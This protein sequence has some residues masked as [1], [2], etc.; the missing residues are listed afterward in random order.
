MRNYAF[1]IL[2]ALRCASNVDGLKCYD[3]CVGP[4]DSVD[5][6]WSPLFRAP[7]P[8][9]SVCLRLERL[10][11]LARGGIYLQTNFHSTLY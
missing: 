1:E 2:V 7:G 3:Y 10:A 6:F 8:P 5:F 11:R 4:V 9:D